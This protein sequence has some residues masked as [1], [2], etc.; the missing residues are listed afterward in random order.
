MSVRPRKG[1][2]VAFTRED[3]I[4]R[5][6]PHDTVAGLRFTIVPQHGAPALI[7]YT[8]L[9]P[10]R[11]ALTFARALRRLAAPGGSLSVR[12]T[13][14]AYA[15]THPRFFK[16]L[17]TIDDRIAGAED[18]RGYHIDGF[19]AWLEAEGLSRT[20]LFTVLAKIVATLRGV[21]ADAP[22]TLAPD[23]LER[24]RYI[25]AKPFQRSSPRDA[26][27]PFVARQLRDAARGDVE[28]LFRRIGAPLE[29]CGD[30]VH[31][32]ALDK[33]DA[34]INE[35]GG[36]THKQHGYLSLY[37]I[38][39]RRGLPIS[40]LT[41][42]LH[43]R[44]HL[45]A[46]DLPPLLTLL[47]LE[48]GLELECLKALTVDCL[49]NVSA[50]TVEVAYMKRRARGAEHK[51]IRVRDGGVRTPGGL[52]R[53]AIEVTASARRFVPSSCIWIYRCE[54]ELRAGIRQLR[55]TL[56]TWTT[57]HGIVD[58]E[59]KP[60][61][62]VLSQ[63]RKTHKA[64]WYLKT[65]GHMTRFAVGHTVDVAARHYADLPSLR[66]LHEATVAAAFEDA[67][68]VATAPHVLTAEAE[69]AWLADPDARPDL[70]GTGDVGELLDGS[71]DVWLAS[72]SSFYASPFGA[73]GA[74]C[75][76]PF[77]GCLECTNAVITAR[78]L[79]AILAFLT[80]VEEQRGGLSAGDWAAKFGRAHA[81]ITAHIL[82]AFSDEVVADARATLAL[83]P[84]LAYLPPE[85]RA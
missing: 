25:S 27:S 16:Y 26:L 74:P 1:R 68:A 15:T 57:R 48:T 31:R 34:I 58:D 33:V 55:E 83:N 60:L 30:D 42:H 43:G 73:A 22:G 65:E 49:R 52:I 17:Q 71:Q 78:K 62:L 56:D 21:D 79:P 11:L 23:L 84:P 72:C 32:R 59:G 46:S 81:R 8:G 53:R 14:K 12:S 4:D 75:P 10:R 44:H 80:F 13:V 54:G 51:T 82:P 6:A 41:D 37:H 66:P 64:L 18:L 61:R 76:T 5:A 29:A 77:W 70:P 85:A 3:G 69:A 50:G 63:L 28:R 9:R 36:I 7:D 47:S 2:R 45:L 67:L 40:S 20:H 35:Q 24:L 39:A 19:E 38:R